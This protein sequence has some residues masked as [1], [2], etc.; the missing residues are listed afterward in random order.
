MSGM[1]KNRI[2]FFHY[3][4]LSVSIVLTSCGGD[5]RLPVY[6]AMGLAENGIDTVYQTIDDF[7]MTNQSGT[8]ISLKEVE[9]EILVVDFFFTS[10]PSICPRLSASLNRVQKVFGNSDDIRLLSFSVDP[11]RDS[12]ARLHEYAKK[13]HAIDGHWEFLTGDRKATYDLAINSFHL[14]AMEDAAAEGGISHDQRFALVDK[15]RRIRGYYDGT[16]EERVKQ[17]I[18]DIRTL[19]KEYE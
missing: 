11:E 10:C 15:E 8:P 3:L 18:R 7:S 5:D 13:Y 12:V 19:R 2:R 1:G 9:G 17:L 16:V 14:A 4:L 6:Y